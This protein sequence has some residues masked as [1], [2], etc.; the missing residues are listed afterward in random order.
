MVLLQAAM[1]L[2]LLLQAIA[3]FLLFVVFPVIIILYT[4][5]SVRNQNNAVVKKV[6]NSYVALKLLTGCF[7]AA[8]FILGVAIFVFFVF[9]LFVDLSDS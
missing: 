2:G 4:V 6:T 9:Y 3:K 7:Y 1:G 5:R 8:L